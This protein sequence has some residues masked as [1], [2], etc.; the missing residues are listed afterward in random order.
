M[1]YSAAPRTPRVGVQLTWSLIIRTWEKDVISDTAG[2]Y[3]K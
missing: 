3:W 1:P 2:H